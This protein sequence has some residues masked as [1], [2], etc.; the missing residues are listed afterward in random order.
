MGHGKEVEISIDGTA[1]M[2]RD[3]SR[4]IPLGK[5]MDCVSKINTGA[6]CNDD[7]FQFSVGHRTKGPREPRVCIN[8]CNKG[9]GH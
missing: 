4:G 7:V 5:V 9:T 2:V 6:K 3:Y 1:L 8:G